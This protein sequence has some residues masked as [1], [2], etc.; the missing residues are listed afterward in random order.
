MAYDNG[1]WDILFHT[2][3]VTSGSL[4]ISSADTIVEGGTPGLTMRFY[5]TGDSILVTVGQTSGSAPLDAVYMPYPFSA[6]QNDGIRLRVITHNQFLSVYRAGNAWIGTLGVPYISFAAD[7]NLQF[8][9]LSGGSLTCDELTVHELDDWREAVWMDVENDAQNAI[10]TI[11]QERPVEI[12]GKVDGSV[13]FF[14]FPATRAEVTP[15]I[16]YILDYQIEYGSNRDTA[17]D[18]IVYGNDIG[19]SVDLSV[20]EHFGMITRTIRIPNLD[21]GYMKVAR[22]MQAKARQ[23]LEQHALMARLMPELEVG[24]ALI[25]S[26]LTVPATGETINERIAVENINVQYLPEPSMTIQGRSDTTSYSPVP[27]S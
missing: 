21:N 25:V 1:G 27:R 11:I 14:Y 17:S 8:H 20:A 4:A 16:R 9:N 19:V 7:S 3:N 13:A 22:I 10:G 18:A 23:S 24:D 12:V 15:D 2:G 26:G 5:P 6:R